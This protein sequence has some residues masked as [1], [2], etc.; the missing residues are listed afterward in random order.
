[1]D[2]RASL[3]VFEAF[4]HYYGGAM[5]VQLEDH[6]EFVGTQLVHP[7]FFR[8][9]GVPPVVGAAPEPRRRRA[10]GDREPRLRGAQLRRLRRGPGAVHLHREPVLRDRGRHARGSCGFPPRPRCGRRPR[11]IPRTGT[12]PAT[13]TGP[14]PGSRPGVSLEAANARLSALARRLAK[15]FPDTNGQQDVRGR[16]AAR[17]PGE[18]GA[19]DALPHHGRGRPRAAD[20]LRQRRQPDPGARLGP[21]ARARGARGARREPA[22][23]RGPDA[24]G[25]P[26]ALAARGRPGP[27]CSPGSARTRSCAW[28]LATSRCRAST[29]CTRTGPSCSSRRSSP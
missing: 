3:G 8:V 16:A 2:I 11:S 26:R 5:G 15:A 22:P 27:A 28:A 19:R 4:A 10:V 14:W 13:T 18:P 25:E 29:T 23:H 1:M 7:D 9:F 20:R 6:A 24:G 12:A 17:Q 21:L